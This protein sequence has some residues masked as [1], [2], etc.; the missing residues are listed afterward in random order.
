MRFVKPID[1]EMIEQM[2]DSHQ[3]IVTIEDG[4][5]MGGAGAAVL[6]ELSAMQKHNPTLLLA[7][8]D[9]FLDHGEQKQLHA[10]VGLDSEGIERSINEFLAT[11]VHAYYLSLIEAQY[12]VIY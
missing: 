11:R 5:R 12:D 10:M 8:P 7:Y 9:V 3:A 4:A 2:A 1:V 6:E